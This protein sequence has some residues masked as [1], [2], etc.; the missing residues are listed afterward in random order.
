MRT[1]ARFAV[2]LRLEDVA[3]ARGGRTILADVSLTLAPRETLLV[4]GRN[5]AGKTTLLRAIAGLLPVERG[6]IAL[7]NAG[8]EAQDRRGHA[9]Y[10]G[11]ADALKPA[12]TVRENL[13]F[14]AKL[15]RAPIARIEEALAALDLASLADQP[16]ARLSAGQKRRAGLTRLVLSGKPLW[17]LD[18]PAAAIDADSLA[19]LTGLVKAH[20]DKGGAA[21]IATHDRISLPSARAV[22]V[23]PEATA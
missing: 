2:G 13:A 14:W 5:G 9:I 10:A 16:A 6:R 8:S 3:V 11:H 20:C 15:H 23:G 19:R 22:I 18:E 7:T 17:L 21:I 12:L 4:K 1:A